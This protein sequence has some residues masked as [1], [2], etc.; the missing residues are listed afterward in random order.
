MRQR[1]KIKELL[2]RIVAIAL[3]FVMITSG[4]FGNGNVK[5]VKAAGDYYLQLTKYVELDSL[6][7]SLTNRGSVSNAFVNILKDNTREND[8]DY[9]LYHLN[10]IEMKGIMANL[11]DAYKPYII[12]EDR[13]T[14]HSGST[15]YK[16][17]WKDKNSI[18]FTT[19]KTI[20]IQHV[21]GNYIYPHQYTPSVIQSQS[22][23]NAEVTK[24]TCAY[25]GDSYTNT[26]ANALGH[27]YSG[28]V[29]Q[30]QTC[31]NNEIT[32]YTCSRCGTYYDSTTANA[33]GQHS[34]TVFQEG[35]NCQHPAVYRCSMCSAT[36]YSGGYGGHSWVQQSAA[37]CTNAKVLR[38]SV[39]GTTTTEGSALGHD[40]TV[41]QAS[42]NCQHPAIY[43]CSRCSATTYSGSNGSHSW[44]R[45]SAATCTEDE[46]LRCTVCGT[47]T[48]GASKTNHDYSST[49]VKAPT[50]SSKGYTRHS[51]SHSGCNSYYDDTYTYG[52]KFDS[53]GGQLGSMNT[54]SI[55]TDKSTALSTN[56]F[57]KDHY[58]FTG[59]NTK[60][61]GTGTAY[62][63][64]EAVNNIA[65]NS[66][67]ITLYA[68]WTIN[69][70]TVK[71]VDYNEDGSIVD[72]AAN[73]A[74]KSVDWGTHV[75]GSDFG[76]DTMIGTY[77]QD[78]AYISDDGE[79]TVEGDVTI[80]RIFRD[81]TGAGLNGSLI[82]DGVL[83]K[84]S[85]DATVVA[86]PNDV[87]KIEDSAFKNHTKL[88]SVTIPNNTVTEIGANAF[89]GCTSLTSINLPYS[90]KK[91][92]KDAFKGCINL[93]KV[94]VKNPECVFAALNSEEEVKEDNTFPNS[95]TLYGFKGSTAETYASQV[96]KTFRAITD[97]E[98]DFFMN[99]TSMKE[100][101]IPD[102]VVTLGNNAFKNC[103]NLE[104][105]N[106]AN[107]NIIGDYAFQNDAVKEIVIPKTVGSIG[108]FAFDS[109]EALKKLSFE[110]DSIC[111]SI[112]ESA[113]S[114]CRLLEAG[115]NASNK[116]ENVLF[117]PE[118][119][120]TIGKEAFFGDDKIGQIDI[121]GMDT[122]IA[123]TSA[124]P[125]TTKVGCYADSK[126]YKFADT[127]KYSIALFVGFDADGVTDVGTDYKGS[128][129]VSTIAFGSKIETIADEAFQNCGNL[130]EVWIG[131]KDGETKLKKIGNEA[132]S[133]CT[134]LERVVASDYENKLE[135]IG[136]SAFN[137]CTSLVS[138]DMPNTPVLSSIGSEAFNECSALSEILVYNPNC[139]IS[140]NVNTFNKATTLK[141]WSKSTIHDFANTNDR[142]FSKIGA[143]YQIIFNK[144]EGVEG[145]QALYVYNKMILPDIEIPV[146][147]GFTF[148]GYK[149]GDT[150]YY[151]ETGK[152]LISGEFAITD[153]LIGDNAPK[154]VWSEN[155]YNIVYS[156]NSGTGEMDEVENVLYTE[157]VTIAK[158]VYEKAGYTFT[159]WNT[160]SDGTGRTLLESEVS[161]A[162]TDQDG[163]TVTLYAQWKANRYNV[164]FN[165]NGGTAATT[166]AVS[167]IYDEEF[168][169]PTINCT[170][171]YYTFG[172]WTK[173]KDAS[174]TVYTSGQAAK[175]LTTENNATVTLYAKWIPIEYALNIDLNTGI[176]EIGNENPLTYNVEQE[177]HLNNPI[178]PGYE[179]KGWSGDGIEG[180]S[181]DVTIPKGSTG[182]KKYKANWGDKL[183]YAITYDL[184]G[185]SLAE[186]KSNPSS[187]DVET[188][189]FTLSNPTKTGHEFIGWTKNDVPESEYTMTVKKGS[190]GD[191]K[192]TAVY[193][194]CKYKVTLNTKFGKFASET[195]DITEYTYG[196]EVK[197]PTGV[198][199]ADNYFKGWSTDPDA[200]EANVTEISATDIGDKIYYA[201]YDADPMD[202]CLL[203]YRDG[204]KKLLKDD[205]SN[206]D[207]VSAVEGSHSYPGKVILPAM[208]MSKKGYTFAG[209]HA[210]ADLSDEVVMEFEYLGL[211]TDPDDLD[212]GQTS[213]KTFYAAWTPN[214]YN[215]SFDCNGGQINGES[216]SYYTFDKTLA[217][218][219]DVTKAG[220]TFAG[221]YDNAELNG[222][223]VKEIASGISGDK[224]YYAAWTPNVYNVTLYTNNGVVG[225][226]NVT[227]YTYGSDVVLPTDIA[228][229][230]CTFAGWY[231]NK[232]FAGDEIKEI[233]ATDSGDKTFYAKWMPNTYHISYVTNAG[234]IKSGK[235]E[236]YMYNTEVTLPTDVKK[237]GSVFV[238]W[239]DN[240][241]MSGTAVVKISASD[242][243][244][245]TFY[246]KWKNTSKNNNNYRNDGDGDADNNG[247]DNNNNGGNDASAK[248]DNATAA[249]GQSITVKKS[250]CSYIYG[251][252]NK[253]KKTVALKKVTNNKI[254][255]ANI[256]ATIR[257]KGMS[258]KVTAIKNNVFRNFK[259]LKKVTFGKN[260]KSIG[261][262]A[263]AGC[264]RLSSV[265]YDNALQ[266]VH[267]A[268]FKNCKSLKNVSL[269][270]NIKSIGNSAFAGCSKLSNVKAGK[271][272]EKVYRYAFKNDKKLK[273]VS[274]ASKNFRLC[275]YVFKGVNLK[276][277]VKVPKSNVKKLKKT[278]KSKGL[279]KARVVKL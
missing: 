99:E 277:T 116:N 259:K 14:A 153:D 26:T 55:Q 24:Y 156:A 19:Y 258:L 159:G 114:K 88:V 97:I 115:T 84:V 107:V 204:D 41:F 16:V 176:Y 67:M 208:L 217:L 191:I 215:V 50:S 73:N 15:S 90:V 31:T 141:G 103:T 256:P 34:Y 91:I 105:V 205:I 82:T 8:G 52:V 106:L 124:I 111:S 197:L 32:R 72:G 187:Y 189:D 83:K 20:R 242:F 37:T 212:D 241:E 148:K 33:T 62:K 260:I 123:E 4:T 136:E 163:E 38:C 274:I 49:S 278:L 43:K 146:R 214:T 263:F 279:K 132:F 54:Q 227:E 199:K 47:T 25:C 100:F 104:K 137:N 178:K 45:K 29:I 64:G 210:K 194:A 69:K 85:D 236:S 243:G 142:T 127:N 60:A 269:G 11:P 122:E 223:A 177:V 180:V 265:K 192:F 252:Y 109:C 181:K 93:T 250:N 152:C 219:T 108:K 240:A 224:T 78:H 3:A 30:S 151:D 206:Y 58:T 120:K 195:D 12:V 193:K 5:F 246:A 179:F 169:I 48:K 262:S 135:I 201:V 27:S 18:D 182:E 17:N 65:G 40:Y 113:F 155:K 10:Q 268:A 150:E 89:E 36:T 249:S 175:N 42:A 226:G 1:K 140:S 211:A 171:E 245:K 86:I 221:W 173:E 275:K 172:G 244:N 39:C 7:S 239:Y 198:T 9:Y 161:K 139:K 238:G 53:N 77:Y 232:T 183:Q 162:L 231:D 220:Y 166:A 112:G 157:N 56:K 207:S 134:K 158:N 254:A 185:G 35:A 143:S 237:S 200:K 46:V 110:E 95:T 229:K 190:T 44:T 261:N 267:K 149:N 81:Y 145:T 51:C 144:A 248:E 119:V 184:A 126:A 101:V 273:K 202:K 131:G 271:K 23:T 76:S 125:K 121:N 174:G 154:A 63:N 92:G 247:E 80:K 21:S 22:C 228:R 75:R 59:W 66:S 98:D 276:V 138:V 6:F 253:K 188:D 272:L 222:D 170:R 70:Y 218:S 196:K 71:C 186:G 216:V 270:K 87:K 133:D 167:A 94:T 96:T 230:G 130:S 13:G 102:N 203:Y 74:T 129:N 2:K 57:T 213:T 255:T 128:K 68:Q 233:T 61:D 79:K 234:E 165:M 209:W 118:T 251:F 264:S 117:I 164:E 28:S 225:S 235:V 168:S 160:K 266:T 257:Y 147:T